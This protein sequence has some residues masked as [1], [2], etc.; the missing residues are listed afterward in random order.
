VVYGQPDE[1][2]VLVRVSEK[3]K[4]EAEGILQQMDRVG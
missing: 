2:V 4:A 3:T 1:G